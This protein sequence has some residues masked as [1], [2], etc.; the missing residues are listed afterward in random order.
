MLRQLPAVLSAQAASDHGNRI[1]PVA[2]RVS[3]TSS[4]LKGEWLEVDVAEDCYGT[5][6]VILGWVSWPSGW[7]LTWE[8]RANSSAVDTHRAL[9]HLAMEWTLRFLSLAHTVTLGIW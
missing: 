4:L 3:P 8:E 7:T 1:R 2:W 9:C 6:E 5:R